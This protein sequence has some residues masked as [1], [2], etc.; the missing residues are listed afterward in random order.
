[1]IQGREPVPPLFN[2]RHTDD[3]LTELAE[4]LGILTGKGGVYDFLN[5]D[6]CMW[7][8]EDGLCLT[9]E[10]QLD[11]DT[12]HT[13]EEIFDK[14]IRS[15]RHNKKGWGL[16]DL[17]ATGFLE[18]RVPRKEFYNYYWV[19]GNKTRHPFYYNQLK[20]FGDELRR[21]LDE[22]GV[23]IPGIDDVEYIFELYR[24]V[25][26][27]VENS[28]FRAPEEFDLWAMNWRTPYHAND[29]NSVLGNPW[30]AEI[31]KMD[32]TDGAVCINPVAAERKGLKEGD[33][34]RVESRYGKVEGRVHVSSLF[35]PDAVGISGCYGPKTIHSNPLIS[36]GPHFNALLSIDERTLDVTAGIDI[37]PRV[38]VYKKDNE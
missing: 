24:P 4:R 37:A 36:K 10:H 19:P 33:W 5:Q 2:T 20:A 28:E 7:S 6:I 34:V 11:I 13:L 29:G 32:P 1:M 3:I 22:S 30:L 25:P 23:S 35:H 21:N 31:H 15:W 17:M 26:H 38:K 14:Q 16:A 9:G 12:Q 8:A 27:W 18:H